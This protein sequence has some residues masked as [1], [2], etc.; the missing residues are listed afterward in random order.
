MTADALSGSTQAPAP[1]GSASEGQQ[2]QLALLLDPVFLKAI[3]WMPPGRP[4]RHHLSIPSSAVP[5]ASSL[6]AMSSPI[7]ASGC[8]LLAGVAT[9][10]AALTSLISS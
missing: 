9:G 2:E 6:A 4:S 5:S 10:A 1:H 8:A 7:T 3:G